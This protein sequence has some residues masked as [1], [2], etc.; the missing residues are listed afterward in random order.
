MEHLQLPPQNKDFVLHGK[1]RGRLE[2]PLYLHSVPPLHRLLILLQKYSFYCSIVIHQTG[3]K[4]N[5]RKTLRR[6]RLW[7]DGGERISLSAE[8]HWARKPGLRKSMQV[9]NVWIVFSLTLRS[10]LLFGRALCGQAFG[11]RALYFQ[12]T[13]AA[14]LGKSMTVYTSSPH[15]PRGKERRQ[16]T[17]WQQI[18]LSG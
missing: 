9:Q 10:L 13:F 7:G 16:V 5:V 1:S 4:A 17:G 12:R 15:F 3:E 18:G 2:F 8:P 14:D 6:A 11:I